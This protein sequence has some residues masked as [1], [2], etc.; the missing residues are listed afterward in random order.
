VD[1]ASTDAQTVVDGVSMVEKKVLKSLGGHG[2]EVV[3]P[4][5]QPFDPNHHEAVGTEPAESPEM[6]H[7]VARVYQQGYLFRGQLL[8]PARVVVR[9]WPG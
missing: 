3:N 8:R 4:I 7:V 6:D 2:L 9:Q 5:D 1:P